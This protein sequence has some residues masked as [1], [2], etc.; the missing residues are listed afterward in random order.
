MSRKR[1]SVVPQSVLHIQQQENFHERR[2]KGASERKSSRAD[3]SF[4]PKEVAQLCTEL[5]LKDCKQIFDPFAGWGERHFYCKEQKL[6]YLGFDINPKAIEI[7]K[8]TF[9]V[10]NTLANSLTDDIPPFD[11]LL[12]CP[13]YWNLETYSNDGIDSIKTWEDFILSY[14][15]ILSK[16]WNSAEE[17][18]TFCI[19]VGDW[20]TDAVYYDLIYQTQ[21]IMD[22]MGATP[23]DQV[24]GHRVR[25]KV[26]IMVPQALS[27][28]YTVKVHEQLLVYKK[29][30]YNKKVE[31]DE[32][33]EFQ[34]V[35]SLFE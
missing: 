25:T 28:G 29:G 19:Y 10:D 24:V 35:D 8:E 26:S 30:K 33:E 31:W 18:A 12:T 16:A 9:G 7:A 27:F 15:A 20:R 34:D 5:Y 6:P 4:F 11:G 17:G 2:E 13:P 22:A 3:Y 1:L 32:V 14:N 21:K 23:F